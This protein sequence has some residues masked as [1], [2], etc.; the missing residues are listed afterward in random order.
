MLG[1]ADETVAKIQDV[2]RK[3]IYLKHENLELMIAVKNKIE[4]YVEMNEGFQT[5]KIQFDVN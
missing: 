1:P 4:Q 5:V 3:V 2:Y